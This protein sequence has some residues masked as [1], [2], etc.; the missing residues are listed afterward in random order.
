MSFWV[1]KGVIKE[2]KITK[3]KNQYNNYLSDFDSEPTIY[4]EVDDYEV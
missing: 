2:K 4:F 3:K 1:H